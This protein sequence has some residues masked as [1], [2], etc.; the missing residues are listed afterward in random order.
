M[1]PI[2]TLFTILIAL[3][4]TNL[5]A[6]SK[7]IKWVDKNGVTQYGDRLPLPSNANKASVLSNQGITVEKIEQKGSSTEQDQALANQTRHDR[8]L[9][10]SYNS[11]EE[12]EIARKR[13]TKTDELALSTLQQ[14]LDNLNAEL[15]KNNKT[16]LAYAKENKVAP[17]ANVG[18]VESNIADIAKVERQIKEKQITINEINQRYEKD[19]VRYAELETRKGKLHDIKY[20]KKNLIELEK[21]RDDAQRRI[22]YYEAKNLEYKRSGYESPPYIKTG[23][24]N[25][26][27]EL[28][29]ANAEIETN[30]LSVKESN[31]QLSR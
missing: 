11:I 21:W 9:L 3:G 4:C 2:F 25:A 29:R 27:K 28:E 19:K 23:L 26:T 30:K 1:K 31:A 6:G 14:K 20:A 18:A 17:V 8:A 10:A 24:L 22:E 12:I 15:T 13:N 16:L 7:I 5:Y